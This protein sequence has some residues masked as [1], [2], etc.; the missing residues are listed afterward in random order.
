MKIELFFFGMG[1]M[2]YGGHHDRMVD[3]FITT[4]ATSAYHH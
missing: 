3:G 4:C 1:N 2:S